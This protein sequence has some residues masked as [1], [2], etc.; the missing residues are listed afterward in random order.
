[1]IYEKLTLVRFGLKLNEGAYN[2]LTGAN[3]AI[4][5]TNWSES[6]KAEAQ[7][8][9]AE[10]FGGS[11]ARVALPP[12]KA[13]AAAPKKAPAPAPKKAS[14]SSS[15][16][17]HATTAASAPAPSGTQVRSQAELVTAVE[18]IRASV[19]SMGRVSSNSPEHKARL[20]RAMDALLDATLRL[21]DTLTNGQG[22]GRPAREGLEDA[23]AA[24]AA[25]P[26]A[27]R[28]KAPSR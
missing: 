21:A 5:K 20:N 8:M 6:E 13:S 18:T 16:A 25:G 27:G 11:K 2:G 7:Q 3:R 12:K 17:S 24:H 22:E 28:G 15:R 26:R 1:M 19:D 14:A 10:Y 4:G 23:E 9:A